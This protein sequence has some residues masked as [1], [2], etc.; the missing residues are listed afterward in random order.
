MYDLAYRFLSASGMILTYRSN[1]V[2]SKLANYVV[3]LRT[4]TQKEKATQC[5]TFFGT[6]TQNETGLKT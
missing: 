5:V 3:S 2:A 1:D 6:D 4:Q